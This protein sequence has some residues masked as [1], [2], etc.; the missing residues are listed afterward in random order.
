MVGGFLADG[1]TSARADAYSP[2]L[3]RWRRLPNLPVA[4]N[5]AMAASVGRRVYVVGGYAGS[6]GSGNAVRGA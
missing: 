1:T 4:V 3:D 2:R 6:I 5:H